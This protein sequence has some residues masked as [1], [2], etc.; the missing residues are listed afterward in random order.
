MKVIETLKEI[1]FERLGGSAEE[2][3]AA[4]VI[5]KRLKL[6]GGKPVINDFKILTFKPGTASLKATKPYNK[7]YKAYPV[8]LTGKGKF[9]GKLKYVETGAEDFLE[10]LEN[11]I[12]LIQGR[13]RTREYKSL[14]KHKAK[15]FISI[16]LP[17]REIMYTSVR[18][19]AV[20]NFGRI[21]GI[22]I[23]FENALEIMRKS[24]NEVTMELNQEEYYGNSGNVVLD[25]KGTHSPEEMIIICGHYDSVI[26][27]AGVMD[28]GA[29][30]VT[31]LAL[32]EWFIKHPTR[33]TLRFIWFGSE[34]M[35]LLGSTEYVERNKKNLENI[36]IVV[37]IDVGGD[38]LGKNMAIITGPEDV[39][40]FVEAKSKELGLGFNVR[41]HVY[42]SDNM[43][44]A[45]QGVPSL[46]LL[47]AGGG[48]FY[49]HT[50]GDCLDYV[51]EKKII[52]IK[53]F[54]MDFIRFIGN[55]KTFPF[56]REIPVDVKK[57]VDEYY[58]NK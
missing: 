8:G 57:K 21:P 56:S 11:K 41:Q 7:T 19:D 36:K 40:N 34:E 44:F 18:E 20:K 25:I 27:S 32:A 5:M 1:A 50:S 4:F 2:R 6:M 43:P 24:A 37:N 42:S 14:V 45:R 30:T 53:N 29:G 46:N 22:S 31:L 55:A 58:K 9:K 48:S 15:G 10:N 39:K 54:A 35:G 33:R 49:M 12:A 26:T 51:D 47:R 13:V 52:L 38:I 16:C 17:G 23:N 28:N 3:R